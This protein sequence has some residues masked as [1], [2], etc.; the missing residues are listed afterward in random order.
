LSV[1]LIGFD[2]SAFAL[3]PPQWPEIKK[4]RIELSFDPW[5]R[6]SGASYQKSETYVRLQD[7]AQTHQNYVTG[8]L[9][10]A[11]GKSFL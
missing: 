2:R 10:R 6:S 3:R 1:P 8:T 5:R 9:Q 7:W 4:H 11:S